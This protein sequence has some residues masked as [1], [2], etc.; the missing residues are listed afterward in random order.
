VRRFLFK[1]EKILKLREN[2]EKE[3]ELELGKAVGIL[4]ALEQRIKQ[5]AEAKIEAFQSR[6]STRNDFIQIRNYDLYIL[7]LDQ[8]KEAL[9][10]AAARAEL[11]VE[12]VKLIY[13]EAS[14]ERKIMSKL[15]E[16]QEKEYRKAMR[17]EE[18][19]SIDDLSGGVSARKIAAGQ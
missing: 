9:L 15:K 17:L 8:T 3:T 6:F 19:K 12:R 18:I 14:R 16:R 4:S 1:Q 5:V 13:L 7:R 2:R 10:A 11:E